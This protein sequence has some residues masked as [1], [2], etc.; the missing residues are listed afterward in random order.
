LAVF[1]RSEKTPRYSDYR[2]YKPYLRRDFIYQCAYC[3]I[4]EAEFGGHHNFQIDHFRPQSLFPEL[5]SEYSN[6]YYA[7]SICNNYKSDT[8]PTEEQMKQGRRF[9]D[10]CADDYDAHFEQLSDFTLRCKSE[11]ARYTLAQLRLNRPQLVQLRQMRKQQEQTHIQRIGLYLSHL[12]KIDRLLQMASLPEAVF[13][14]LTQ[15]RFSLKQQLLDEQNRWEN[16]LN[17]PY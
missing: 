14:M 8:W 5:L 3:R 15:M 11:P 7:C 12:N 6:L 4:H 2:R 17:P 9:L 1:V 16:R 10:L 13:N